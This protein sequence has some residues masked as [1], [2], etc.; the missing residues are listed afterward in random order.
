MTEPF[1]LTLDVAQLVM[2]G[3][4][5]WGLAKMSASVSSLRDV[6][7]ELTRGLKEIGHGLADMVTRVA[8]LEQ[9]DRR[10]PG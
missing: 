4:L 7:A 2:L 6:T 10:R 5:I 9:S 1:K 3:G 8:L